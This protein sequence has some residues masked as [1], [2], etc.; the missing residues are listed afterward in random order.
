MN[1]GLVFSLSAVV[2]L[3][4]VLP[5][6][7]AVSQQGSL[8]QQLVG[9]W[10]LVSIIATDK[11]GNKSDR[12]GPNPKGLL[13][14]DASGRYSILTSLATLP[15]FAIDNV[16]QGTAEENKAVM[17][18]MIANVGTWSVDEKTKTITTNVEAGSFPNLN[19]K[20]QK[21]VVS[22]LTPDELRYVNGASVSG[23]VDEATWRRAK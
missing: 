8:Q 4:L 5:P 6:T 17:T 2:A 15:N 10:T 22:L 13:I 18:G 12:R 3:A 23:T 14:F 21:R 11:A 19:G 20:T 7:A 1:R 16:N 9:A